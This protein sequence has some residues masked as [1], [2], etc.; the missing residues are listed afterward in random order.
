[1]KIRHYCLGIIL[2][3]L[4]LSEGAAL[5]TVRAVPVVQPSFQ[6]MLSQKHYVTDY[7]FTDGEWTV[8]VKQIGSDLQ[9]DGSKNN[10]STGIRI[11]GVRRSRSNG[12]LIYTWR[13]QNI[14]YIVIWNPADPGFARLQVTKSG[15]LVLNRLLTA[16][17]GI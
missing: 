1:M 4:L 8:Q 14:S 15:R 9:Y 7:A 5:A 6:N 2:G 10:E 17:D 3:S 11:T 16:V 13:N 12:R